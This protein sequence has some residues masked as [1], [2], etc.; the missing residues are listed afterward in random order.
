MPEQHQVVRAYRASLASST[1]LNCCGA[2]PQIGFLLLLSLLAGFRGCS[3]PIS[4]Q[5]YSSLKLQNPHNTRSSAGSE[6][7]NISVLCRCNSTLKKFHLKAKSDDRQL[8]AIGSILSFSRTS[9]APS[10]LEPL[11]CGQI[12]PNRQGR[13]ICEVALGAAGGQPGSTSHE[14]GQ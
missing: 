7:N 1:G 14:S 3:L 6:K 12:L 8:C 4:C 10:C 13:A 11:G 2:A 5:V 9:K